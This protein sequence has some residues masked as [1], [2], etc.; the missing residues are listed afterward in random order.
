[1]APNTKNTS[2]SL[3]AAVTIPPSGAEGMIVTQGGWFGGYGLYL[4][5]GKPTFA[6]ARSHYPEHKYIVAGPAALAPGDH[7][8]RVDF[9]FDGGP[10]GSGGTATVRVDGN[11]VAKGRVDQTVPV[12]FSLDETLD[13]GEDTGTPVVR[14]YDVPFRFTGTLKKVVI[15]I[16]PTG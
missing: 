11:E 5:Q 4:M 16:T 9:A 2:Y 6:Y 14:D 10:A 1:M 13:I 12:R 15:D 8:I 7:E 3:T